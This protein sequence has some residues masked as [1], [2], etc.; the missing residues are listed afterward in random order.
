MDKIIVTT[1]TTGARNNTFNE[2]LASLQALTNINGYQIEILVVENNQQPDDQVKKII[3]NYDNSDKRVNHLLEPVQGIP[4]ARNAAL[5]YA[6]QR[7]YTY[8]AFIDDDAFASP[9]WIETLVNA[10]KYSNVASGPQLAIFPEGTSLFYCNATVYQ[11][12]KLADGAEIKWSATNNVLIDVNFMNINNLSFNPKLINGGE[13][14]ELFLRVNKLGGKIIWSESSVVSE[15]I[16]SSRLSVAWAMR[17]TFRI[18]AT[19]FMIESAVR[20]SFENYIT[21]IIK[22]LLYLAKGLCLLPYHL[23][24]SK[25]SLLNS[26]C[27]L[28]HGVGFFYGLFS[29]GRVSKYT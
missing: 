29:K 8:L 3:S 24:S 23:I 22:G 13:D 5:K 27:D 25:S 9:S 21:C 11:E 10:N 18:G 15:Y 28:S 20:T 6:K 2:C 12:R 26:L 14:K 17:R 19:G 7:G 1:L 16:A 4:S